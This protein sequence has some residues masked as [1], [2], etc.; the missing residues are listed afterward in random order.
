MKLLVAIIFVKSEGVAKLLRFISGDKEIKV[1]LLK[2]EYDAD[3]SPV[4]LL[5]F[6]H[7]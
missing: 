3:I 1:S 2:N 6:Q 5:A 4:L 7:W